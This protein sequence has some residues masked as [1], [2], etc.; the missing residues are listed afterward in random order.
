MFIPQFS[1][2]SRKLSCSHVNKPCLE[3]K[4]VWYIKNVNDQ[5][6]PL[7]RASR[8]ESHFLPLAAHQRKGGSSSRQQFRNILN[9]PPMKPLS[10]ELHVEQFY[11]QQFKVWPGDK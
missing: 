7:P 11:P 2:V 5:K 10:L 1:E 6:Y 9:S 3:T 8:W 4:G